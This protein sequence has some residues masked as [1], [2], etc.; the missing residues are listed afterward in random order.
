MENMP[1]NIGEEIKGPGKQ[2]LESAVVDQLVEVV[3]ELSA[4]VWTH[5][6]HVI[7]LES[8]LS[9]ILK[10]DKGIDLAQLVES[11]AP[12]PAELA[13][14]KEERDQYVVDVFRSFG[15]NIAAMDRKAS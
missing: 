6:D 9:D 1:D 2:F 10:E 11:R 15:R 14:R 4:Q 8:V 7:V 12:D 13:A 5:R 3:V